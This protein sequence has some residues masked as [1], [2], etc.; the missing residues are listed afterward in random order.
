MQARGLLLAADGCRERRDRAPLRG[1]RGRGASMAD[2]VRSPGHRRCRGDREGAWSQAVATARSYRGGPPSDA[3]RTPS[4]TSPDHCSRPKTSDPNY[5][6]VCEEPSNSSPTDGSAA[7]R[8]T[9]STTTPKPSPPGAEHWNHDPKPF[10]WKATPTTSSGRSNEAA[11]PSA[12][13][14]HRR[15]I[16]RLVG[17]GS[18]SLPKGAA[19]RVEPPKRA[20]S[21]STPP[22]PRRS[23]PP[24]RP[25]R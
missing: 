22:C 8:S 19:S 21:A 25:S 3:Q 12:R 1:R 23:V 16:R 11:K 9:A 20:R 4:T 17:W 2:Q 14:I 10:I 7:A 5:T 6:L 15:T 24:G 18:P 13:S